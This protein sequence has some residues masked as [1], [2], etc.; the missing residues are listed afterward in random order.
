[1]SDDEGSSSRRARRERRERRRE[2]RRRG[3]DSDDEDDLEAGRG[4]NASTSAASNAQ[5]RESKQNKG[6]M[7]LTSTGGV[8]GGAVDAMTKAYEPIVQGIEQ[9]RAN[10]AK[11]RKMDIGAAYDEKMREAQTRKLDALVNETTR[12]GMEVKQRLDN[13]KQQNWEQ[14][15]KPG[16]EIRENLFKKHA[17]DFQNAFTE[18]KTV[19][20][21][22]KKR[23]VDD[24][25]RQ[26]TTVSQSVGQPLSEE[27][28]EVIISAG[29][30]DSVIQQ[31]MMEDNARLYD[32]VAD[33][34][35][36][37]TEILKLES[38]VHQVFELFKD[39]ATLVDIQQESLDM[40]DMNITKAAEHVKKGEKELVEAREQ[41]KKA[42][43]R[44]A[45]LLVCLLVIL[46]VILVPT[47][48]VTLR[49]A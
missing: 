8:S 35:D 37:H 32:I 31:V 18:Y 1:M 49:D 10:T 11:L 28:I 39:L 17:L 26:L 3:S 13:L 36:R 41:Q 42:R 30:A 44:R 33:I 38:Q 47:L 29:K 23:L 46:I 34:E 12:I 24:K 4:R 27:Q 19:T 16:R 15:S 5:V 21:D 6:A 2:R 45:F 48:T 20:E 7:E 22:L 43:K 14:R 25:R 40:I 9:I